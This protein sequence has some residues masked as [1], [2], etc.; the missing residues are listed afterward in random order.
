MIPN[1]HTSGSPGVERL[2]ADDAGICLD[3]GV[4]QRKVKQQLVGRGE[5]EAAFIADV[6]PRL[7]VD[8]R[9]L[10]KSLRLRE[11]ASAVFALERFLAGVVAHVGSVLRRKQKRLR[12]EGARIRALVGVDALVSVEIVDARE[13][14]AT[15][16][17][18]ITSF[19]SMGAHVEVQVAHLQ[20][21]THYID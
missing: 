16:I 11:L 5:S 3:A 1:V 19:S 9:M 17:T 15:C 12:T 20:R 8:V 10:V 21:C 2:V 13:S 14:L 6:R 4:A 7:Q 18:G